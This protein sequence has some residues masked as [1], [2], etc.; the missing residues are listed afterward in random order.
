VQQAAQ[1]N[2]LRVKMGRPKTIKAPKTLTALRLP[3]E[4]IAR[5]DA[6]AERLQRDTP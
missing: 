6:Y 5:T 2:A 1:G 4:L 3:D